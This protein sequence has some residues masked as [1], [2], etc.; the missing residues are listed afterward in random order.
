[1]VSS[2][3]GIGWSTVS[4]KVSQHAGAAIGL[5]FAWKLGLVADAA[6]EV[7]KFLWCGGVATRMDIGGGRLISKFLLLVPQYFTERHYSRDMTTM[8]VVR[9]ALTLRRSL[10]WHVKEAH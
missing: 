4:Y 6:K 5:V 2:F 9:S 7:P 10:T 1:M 3:G 8:P